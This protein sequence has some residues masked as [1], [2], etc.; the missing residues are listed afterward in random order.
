[1]TKL[2]DEFRQ[3]LETIASLTSR[4]ALLESF[5][6]DVLT[7]NL[8]ASTCFAMRGGNIVTN[9]ENFLHPQY[10]PGLGFGCYM[11]E[12]GAVADLDNLNRP[13]LYDISSDHAPMDGMSD[14]NVSLAD[15]D[16]T[17]FEVSEVP[18]DGSCGSDGILMMLGDDRS[19]EVTA[20][21]CD[22]PVVDGESPYDDSTV[23]GFPD[24]SPDILCTL[25]E[26]ACVTRRQLP[27]SANVIDEVFHKRE[28]RCVRISDEGIGQV[29]GRFRPDQRH[30]KR[31]D[32]L[33]VARTFSSKKIRVFDMVDVE[34]NKE[35]QAGQEP[36][37][38][39]SRGPEVFLQDKVLER[40]AE[41]G[42]ACRF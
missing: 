36:Q 35:V 2:E 20:E 30:N 8:Q 17:P 23:S 24:V 26:S 11:P 25:D 9:T 13:E 5:L 14:L 18:P 19:S 22:L 34:V 4:M 38:A 31:R 42:L 6:D 37:P 21:G 15:A 27:S 3:A 32:E 16:D 39:D 12:I 29:T 41:A 1:M 7:E 33:L 28:T 40:K 10:P